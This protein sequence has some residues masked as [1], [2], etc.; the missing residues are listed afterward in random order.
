MKDIEKKQVEMHADFFDRC[1][2]AIQNGHYLEAILMEYAAIESRLESI[3]GVLGLPCGKKCRYRKDI[4]IGTRI[5]CLR[6]Y[7]NK[8]KNIF[9]KSKLP[10]NF[11]TNNGELKTWIGERDI[12]VHGL[13]KDGDSFREKMEKNKELSIEGKYYARLL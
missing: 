2:F 12:R 10:S 7:R 1:D 5:E 3:C 13:Y 8:N 4:K 9:S 11:F 6:V